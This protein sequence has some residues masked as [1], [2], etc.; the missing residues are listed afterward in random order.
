VALSWAGSLGLLWITI[1]L[2]VALLRRAPTLAL[3]VVAAVLLADATANLLKPVFGRD[4]PPLRYPSPEPLVPVP[5]TAAFPSGHAAT[6]F[7]GAV[8][9]A[10][11]EPRLRWPL[12][13]LAAL[14]AWSRV[15]VGVHYPL[16]VVAGAALGAAI[17]L[18]AVRALLPRAGARPRSP[19]SRR[20]G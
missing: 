4:R 18:L 2:A 16:D 7:A 10:A 17:G 8:V 20:S 14:V 19:R 6:S 12:L 13:V 5:G 9:L 1:G 3:V 15:Y 11:V